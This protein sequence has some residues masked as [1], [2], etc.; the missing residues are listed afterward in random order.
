MSPVTIKHLGIS[1]VLLLL[2]GIL[3]SGAVFEI[4]RKSDVLRT[5]VDVLMAEQAQ[6]D[7]YYK[8][9]KIS[10]ETKS[11]REQ[12]DR[13]F[14][15]QGSDSIDVL[16]KVEAL[17]PQI[18]VSLKTDSLEEQADKKAGT[19]WIDITFSFSGPEE[20]VLQFLETLEHLPYFSQI[21]A[22]S[23][24]ESAGSGWSAKVTMKLFL[25]TT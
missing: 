1:S 18:G 9:Q 12:I 24:E 16:N 2:A 15:K 6:A 22:V 23:L 25:S 20:N 14:L 10:E 11:E 21:T 3:C 8:L 13:Y 5:Q 4:H 17:A 19:K 7:S